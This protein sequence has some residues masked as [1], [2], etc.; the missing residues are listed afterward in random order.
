MVPGVESPF[1]VTKEAIKRYLV[2]DTDNSSLR[3]LPRD[4]PY[5]FRYLRSIFFAKLILHVNVELEAPSCFHSTEERLRVDCQL[6]S[7]FGFTFQ[8]ESL[9]SHPV[10]SL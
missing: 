1:Y 10:C 9:W 4:L 7:Y 6:S 3:S 5:T 2:M 8:F